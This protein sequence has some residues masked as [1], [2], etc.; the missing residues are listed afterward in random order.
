M[1]SD[2][3]LKLKNNIIRLNK[4]NMKLIQMLIYIFQRFFLRSILSWNKN[5]LSQLF[6]ILHLF[7]FIS[8]YSSCSQACC[9]IA[10]VRLA[11]TR[12]LSKKP[13][14]SLR[15]ACCK[16]VT[17]LFLQVNFRFCSSCEQSEKQRIFDLTK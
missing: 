8:S 12:L 9:R 15:Q 11:F 16:L 4:V 1:N 13:A 2:K 7:F 6:L 17:S 5:I 14:A 3:F 10:K